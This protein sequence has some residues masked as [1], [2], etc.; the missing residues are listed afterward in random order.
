[1]FPIGIYIMKYY[2]LILLKDFISGRAQWLTPVIPALWEAEAGRSRGQEIKTILANMNLTLLLRLE[3]S[4]VISAHCSFCLPGSIDCPASATQVTGI[5]GMCYH[6]FV[7][8]VEMEFHCVG[9]AGIELLTPNDLPTSA[10]QIAEI[11]S[12]DSRLGFPP[13]PPKLQRE[14]LQVSLCHAD[15][16]TVLRSRFTATSTS[17]FKVL[18]RLRYEDGL[19]L[20]GGGCSEPRSHHCTPT[21]LIEGDYLKRRRRRRRG[22]RAGAQCHDLGSLQPLPPPRLKQSFYLSLPSS[23][24]HRHA[25]PCLESCSVA[26]AGVSAPQVAPRVA[27]TT[28]TCHHAWL[29]FVFL[30]EM[31]F[32]HIGQADLELLTS[33]M[34]LT[35]LTKLISSSWV[36]VILP[37]PPVKVL[38][39]QTR[40]FQ[41][42][43]A[44]QVSSTAVSAGAVGLCTKN[45]HKSGHYFNWWLERLGDRVTHSPKKQ[46]GAL[47]QSQVIWMGGWDPPT[48]T[49]TTNPHKDHQSETLWIVSFTASTAGPG[50]VQLCWGKGICHYRGS[51]PLP[52]QS[53]TTEA[54][55]H[56]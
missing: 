7:F 23:L 52:R 46:K 32:H 37:H 36:Q 18:G 2:S 11:A 35:M 15:W 49:K 54:V 20:R 5:T 28:G 21:W 55:C 39:L 27:R 56:Y 45:S 29:I 50:M 44:P 10:S 26:Q 42:G 24:D 25:P 16:S 4:D 51:P 48:L 19:N 22:R 13:Q 34:S 53:A 40:I 6:T 30:V 43:K 3:C 38:G 8:L 33:E 1:M 14:I 12:W 9:Q 31:G 41:G 17:W 47:K